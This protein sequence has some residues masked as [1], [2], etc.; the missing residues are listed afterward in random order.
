M[1]LEQF[2]TVDKDI[3]LLPLTY[4]SCVNTKYFSEFIELDWHV[5]DDIPQR[6]A[7]K[8]QQQFYRATKPHAPS[9]S[10]THELAVEIGDVIQVFCSS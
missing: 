2:N 5:F 9:A 3:L 1:L 6:A 4:D 7:S 10:N 8:L